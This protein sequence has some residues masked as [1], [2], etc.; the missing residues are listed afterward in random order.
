M[1]QPVIVKNSKIHGKGVFANKDFK[2]GEIVI[3]WNAKHITKEDL[4]KLSEKDKKFVSFVNEEY[5]LM[6]EPE[7]FVNHSCEPNTFPKNKCDVA[8]KPIKKGEEIT[9]DYSDTILKESQFICNCGNKNCKK[10]I[11]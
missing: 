2:K 5:L 1:N 10:I 8:I 7:R 11:K 6:N 4:D 9:S 3:K